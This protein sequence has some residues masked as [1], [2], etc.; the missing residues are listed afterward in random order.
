M[1]LIRSLV[2]S[3]QPFDVAETL[4]AACCE[5][6]NSIMSLELF[7]HCR[8]RGR[9]V[10]SK[11]IYKA[12]GASQPTNYVFVQHGDVDRQV[13]RRLVASVVVQ[14]G[15]R[16]ESHIHGDTELCFGFDFR[17]AINGVFSLL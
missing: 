12:R 15:V 4:K 14:V 6:L 9:A 8:V 7:N 2:S 17:Y 13:R 10:V 16:P 11:T 1:S 3:G 5:N